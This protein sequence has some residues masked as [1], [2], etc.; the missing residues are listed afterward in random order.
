M[1]DRQVL[2]FE[3]RYLYLYQTILVWAVFFFVPVY[4]Q[5]VNIEA[6]HECGA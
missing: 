6:G 2:A 3:S 4:I 1:H 5:D